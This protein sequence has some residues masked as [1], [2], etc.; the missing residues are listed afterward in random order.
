MGEVDRARLP[1]GQTVRITLYSMHTNMR[2][3]AFVQR[4]I[5]GFYI[6]RLAEIG[7]S[8]SRHLHMYFADQTSGKLSER[9]ERAGVRKSKAP[10]LQPWLLLLT[11]LAAIWSVFSFNLS[12]LRS[13]GHSCVYVYVLHLYS[14][15]L[16]GWKGV[17]LQCATALQPWHKTWT[18]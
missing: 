4:S 13:L 1:N 15:T 3:S 16:C 7:L 18:W 2:L 11:L 6:E 14:A 9:V 5:D 12:A 10:T 8:L 17:F